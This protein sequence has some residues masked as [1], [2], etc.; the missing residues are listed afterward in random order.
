MNA[1]RFQ[2]ITA[3]YSAL[4]LA[5]M[6]DFCLDRYLEIDPF[7]EE[8]SIETGLPVH[9]VVRVRSQP[10]GAGTIVNNLSALSVGDIQVIGFAGWDGEGFELKQALG[11]RAGVGVNHFVQTRHRRT[12]TYCKPLLM[13]PGQPPVELNRLDSKNWDPTPAVV[14]GQ[15]M[16]G[17]RA[18]LPEVNGLVLLDQVDVPETGVITSRILQEITQWLMNLPQ[19]RILAD[20]RR[21]LRD[22]PPV[23]FKM[24]LAELTAMTGGE[25]TLSLDDA[26][27]LA[28]D[29]AQRNQQPV[30]VTMAEQGIVGADAE[31]NVEHAPALP[32]RGAIDVVGAG[33]AVTANLMASLAAGAD[34]HEALELANAAASVVIHQLGTTGTAT[35]EQLQNVLE[36]ER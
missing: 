24:N 22:Y 8:T 30:F 28:L 11:E 13:K 20:S 9:N 29:L 6:G 36:F 27:S 23:G 3:R 32:L 35:V 33:D 26:K 4:R 1:A 2:E 5:V 15:M 14:E 25:R 17:W 7:K 21:G 18:V 12:F 10:G 31:G 19:Q 34:L 16:D